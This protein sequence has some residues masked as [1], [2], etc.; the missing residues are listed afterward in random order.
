[1]KN[2]YDRLMDENADLSEL[3]EDNQAPSTMQNQEES[4]RRADDFQREL[5]RYR[6]LRDNPMSGMA[7]LSD[8][9]IRDTAIARAGMY[10]DRKQQAETEVEQEAARESQAREGLMALAKGL[11][12]K[13]EADKQQ[14]IEDLRAIGA[15][16]SPE[17]AELANLVTRRLP[18]KQQE[19]SEPTPQQPKRKPASEKKETTQ[20]KTTKS[21]VSDEA[22]KEP[23]PS[24]TEPKD[25]Y[26]QLLEEFKKLREGRKAESEKYEDEIREARRRDNIL[27]AV[28]GISS[29]LANFLT[30]S[31]AEKSGVFVAPQYNAYNVAQ[32]LANQEQQALGER[33]RG[34]EREDKNLADMMKEYELTAKSDERRYNRS[35]KEQ[36][37]MLKKMQTFADRNVKPTKGFEKLDTEFAKDYNRWT[38]GGFD[39]AKL[40]L[41]KLNDV[42]NDLES[43][44]VVTGPLRS[45]TPEFL[46]SDDRLAARADVTSSVIT[47]LREILGAQFT[48]K[49]GERVIKTTWNEEDSPENNA[50]RLRRLVQDLSSQ[51]NQ[52]QRK[53][54]FFEQYGSLQ[55]YQAGAPRAAGLQVGTVDGG[56]RFKGGN[57]N[58]Q[59]NW[60]KVD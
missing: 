8:R 59:K 25:P 12:G 23:A 33:K 14:E 15:D 45:L 41:G 43:G 21:R 48:E 7:G 44:K 35:I 11:E 20:K 54:R 38:S 22:I 13:Y 26:M 1:M 52:K 16:S 30:A 50:R 51:A 24:T 31:D 6:Q 46:T 10:Q 49:E 36:E 17:E 29:G 5:E 60:E 27:K 32:D 28:G 39:S 55:G 34:L 53:S 56:Y 42:I 4:T 18:E 3:V 47:S 2:F 58:D 19:T 57:P 9:D 37:L 40:E